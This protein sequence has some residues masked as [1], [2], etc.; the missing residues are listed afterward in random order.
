[1][2]YYRM[3]LK[4]A[5]GEFTV[6]AITKHSMDD[7]V[8]EEMMWDKPIIRHFDGGMYHFVALVPEYLEVLKDG[9]FIGGEMSR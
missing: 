2:D 7:A 8:L 3:R 4:K 1:M 9:I 6:S 5:D